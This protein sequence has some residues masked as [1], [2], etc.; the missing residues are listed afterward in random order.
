MPTNYKIRVTTKSPTEKDEKGEAIRYG[1]EQE[2]AGPTNF[3][4]MVKAYGESRT[5]EMALDTWKREKQLLLAGALR[6]AVSGA[7]ATGKRS[8]FKGVDVKKI[9]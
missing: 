6:E 5:F 8:Q 3:A 1:T 9:A 2:I 4:E 7:K